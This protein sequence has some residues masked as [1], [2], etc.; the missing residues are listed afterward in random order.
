MERS[1]SSFDFSRRTAL[2]AGSAAALATL[3]DG[4]AWIPNR[5]ALAVTELPDVQFD[6][7]AFIQPA[8]AI[9]GVQVQFG[10]VHTYFETANLKRAPTTAD[11]AALASAL[12]TIE[13]AYEFSPAGVMVFVSYGLG[14]FS[15]LPGGLTGASVAGLRMPRL[16]FDTNR[17]ALEEAKV[18]P[19]RRR[20]ARDRQ[21]EVRHH[22][23]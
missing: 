9:N 12:D 13:T 3:L 11:Q 17:F 19:D 1:Q 6:V 18:A 15:R 20:P 10:P 7:A 2:K 8:T 4:L 14:Y 23:R 16:I 21:A 5:P 22:A